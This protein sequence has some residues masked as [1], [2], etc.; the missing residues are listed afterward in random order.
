MCQ[1]YFHIV[2]VLNVL[3]FELNKFVWLG[4]HLTDSQIM[5][6]CSYSEASWRVTFTSWVWGSSWIFLH[7]SSLITFLSPYTD[8]FWTHAWIKT[9]QKAIHLHLPCKTQ[10]KLRSSYV[11]SWIEH[12]NQ[13]WSKQGLDRVNAAIHPNAYWQCFTAPRQYT[14]KSERSDFFC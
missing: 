4:F 6:K 10:Q 8:H 1:P 14:R 9:F 7:L 13:K 12:I 2:G 3:T 11:L 5:Q